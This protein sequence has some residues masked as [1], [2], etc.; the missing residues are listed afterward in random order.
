MG[1]TREPLTFHSVVL[2]SA[3]RKVLSQIGPYL[4][5]RIFIWEAG[6]PWPFTL[7]IGSPRTSIGSERSAGNDLVA[8]LEDRKKNHQGLG[9]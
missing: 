1:S 3:A 7:V 4:E 6:L 2:S 9:L 8:G 5:D